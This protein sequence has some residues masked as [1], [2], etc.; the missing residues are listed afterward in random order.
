[1]AAPDQAPAG[2]SSRRAFDVAGW[3]LA[4]LFASVWFGVGYLRWRRLRAGAS[5]LG[6][7]DQA[8]WLLSQGRAPFI[9]SIG[10]NVF[11]DHV[12]LVLVLF[13]PLYRIAA[14]PVWLIGFQAICVGLTV[15]PLRALADELG[16]PR[17]LAGA[18]VAAS[19]ALWSA[20]VYDVHPVVFATPAVAWSLLAARR[21]DVRT[22]TI[23]GLLVV[24]CRADIA[25]ALAGVAVVASPGVRRRLL[26]LVPVPMAASVVIPRVLGTWQTFG[27]Y[28]GALGSGWG[29]AL[30]HP[31]RIGAALVAP[32]AL[33]QML[34]WLTPLGFLPLRRPRWFAA[35]FVAGL[36]LVLS[37]WP[38]IIAPWYHHAAYLV[39]IGIGGA[40][41]GWARISQ[42]SKRAVPARALLVPVL[43]LA[44]GA[45][46]TLVTASP[47]A[48]Y[49]PSEV[50]LADVVSHEI[51][52][53]RAGVAAVGPTEAVSSSNLIS[54]HLSRRDEAYNFPC[55]FPGRHG[56]PACSHSNLLD[57]AGNVS[58]VVVVGHRDLGWLQAY[59]RWRITE[60]DDVTIARRVGTSPH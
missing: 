36:P 55:P 21:D 20:V 7:F 60:T 41:A 26:W 24:T 46:L 9:T 22:A 49:A 6:I 33:L 3:T 4:V 35:M 42:T 34:L 19:P 2:P 48:P 38:G 43:A 40:L 27:H 12:S 53:V 51:P 56:G 45:T 16:A 31:W 1:M 32:G 52:G 11:A 47:F 28:Y 37:S 30:V 10:I 57:R 18:L 13:A 5:D 50:R 59:G 54:G 44:V 15:V 58:V 29:D 25:I 14:T 8:S 17:W 23:A 39:P